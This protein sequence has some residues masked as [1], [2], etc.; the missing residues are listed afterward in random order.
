[1]CMD[2]EA[3]VCFTGLEES[4]ERYKQTTGPQF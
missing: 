4:L 1:M 3:W 2:E